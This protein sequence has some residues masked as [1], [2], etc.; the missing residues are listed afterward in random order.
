MRHDHGVSRGVSRVTRVLDVARG[1]ATAVLGALLA[2]ACLV[3]AYAIGPDVVISMHVDP[4]PIVTG[5]YPI[6]HTPDGLTFAWSRDNVRLTLPGL[7]RQHPWQFTI[8]VATPR[9]N[10]AAQPDIFLDVDGVT[11][12]TIRS[13]QDFQDVSIALPT[14]DGEKRGVVIAVRVSDTFVPGPTDPRALG[15]KI[16]EIRLAR[17]AHGVPIVPRQALAGAAV[18]GAIF[19]ALFGLIGLTAG[20]ATLGVTALGCGQAVVLATGAA[21][22]YRYVRDIPEIAAYIA[23]ATIACVWIVERVQGQRLRNTARFVAA[24]SSAALFLELLVLSHPGMPVGDALF[25]AHR[26]E[27]VRDGR[28]FFTSTAPGG[29]EFPYAVGLYV[30]ALTVSG[31]V[32]G[33]WGF[34]WLLRG[35]VAISSAAAGVLLY[36]MIVKPTGNRLAGAIAV[37]LY[38][39]LPLQFQVQTVGNLTNAF[40]QSLFV[41]AIALIVLMPRD[42]L[43]RY[44]TGVGLLVMAILAM[45]SHTSTFAIAVPVLILAGVTLRLF[46]PPD[47]SSRAWSVIALA[48]IATAAAVALYYGHFSETYSAQFAR[49]TGEMGKPAAAS[50]P[51]GRSVAQRALAVPFYLNQ[52]YGWPA[53]V[54]AV[55][56]AVSPVARRRDALTLTLWAWIGGTAAFLLLGVF[57]PL[58]FRHYLAAF[59]A[60]AILAGCGAAYWWTRGP[61]LQAAAIVLMGSSVLIGVRH[62][63]AP[64][65]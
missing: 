4:P 34:V 12:K 43:W 19:G 48:L 65:R 6:E 37:G 22:Y 32:K 58:D 51:G 53:L 63:I 39:L 24:F 18:G 47:L 26:F 62:W 44:A 29:Y 45:L 7:D 33:T 36:P 20:S 1:L 41:V 17:P 14:N 61:F 54:L 8:R 60:V 56:G 9:P 3:V 10:P 31:W 55:I 25:H 30:T 13:T 57:T 40:A 49:I 23:I 64:L 21:P 15:M 42:G 50:D 52:Y 11:L 2:A 27:W 38:F 16:D 46:G 35:I 5:L 28:W 59:P